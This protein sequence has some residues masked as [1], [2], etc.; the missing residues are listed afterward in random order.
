MFVGQTK[1]ITGDVQ[2]AIG[3]QSRLWG[4]AAIEGVEENGVISKGTGR[5]PALSL[6]TG[7]K[8]K[9]TQSHLEYDN[10]IFFVT[11]GYTHVWKK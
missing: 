6:A 2:M 4:L 11:S 3:T 5:C 8:K 10:L 7:V 9:K 1:F